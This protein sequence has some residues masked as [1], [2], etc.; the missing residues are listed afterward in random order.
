MSL[1]RALALEHIDAAVVPRFSQHTDVH[2]VKSGSASWLASAHPRQAPKAFVF[3]RRIQTAA[4]HRERHF[5]NVQV[6]L[7]VDADA[8]RRDE[9]RWTIAE[10]R[11]ADA[12]QT[13]AVAIE[14][15]Q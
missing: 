2:A 13:L 10:R 9:F 8:V 11:I 4:V 5:A 14:H 15:I 12:R 6:A 3:A 7:R 1:Q